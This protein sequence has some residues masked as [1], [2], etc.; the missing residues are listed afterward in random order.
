M[1]GAKLSPPGYIILANFIKKQVVHGPSFR[2]ND[3]WISAR[4]R[5]LQSFSFKVSSF[6]CGACGVLLEFILR[7]ERSGVI[8]PGFP[9]CFNQSSQDFR[10]GFYYPAPPGYEDVQQLIRLSLTAP[11]GSITTYGYDGLNRVND[12]ANSWAGSFGFSYD[13]LSRRTSLTRPNGVNTSYTYDSVSRLLSV[14]HQ[15]GGTTL[16]GASYT[17]DAAGNRTSKTNYL[18]GITDNYAYD[19][20]YQLQQVTEGT[21]TT[22][23]YTYDPVGNRLSSLSVPQYNYNTSNELTSTSLA[24]YSYDHNGNTLTKTDSSGTTQYTWDYENRLTQVTVPQSGGG[25]TLVSFKYDPFGRRIQKSGP[26]GSTNYLYD[27]PNPIEELDSSGNVLA[28][29]TQGGLDEPLSQLRSGVTSYYE[30]DGLGSITSLTDSSGTIAATYNYDSFGTMLSST[31]SIINPFRYTARELDSETGLYYH[32]AR[33][34]DQ[35]TGRFLSEDPLRFRIS[36]NFYPYVGNRPTVHVDPTGRGPTWNFV[37]N[38]W[39]GSPVNLADWGLG[40]AFENAPSVTNAVAFFQYSIMAQGVGLARALCAGKTG[41]QI[42]VFTSDSQTTTDV[43]DVPGLYSVGHSTFFRKA[44][45]TLVADC[46]SHRFTIRSFEHFSIRDWFA[47]PLS[48]GFE[49][50]LSRPYRINYDF[51]R[52]RTIDGTF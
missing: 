42:A 46:C 13:A 37:T 50:P 4:Q 22:E 20:L 3:I 28:R 1:S 25:S 35:G 44:T 30:A 6:R 43:T 48:L 26:D 52:S 17:Y 51:Y 27:S 23:S 15:A 2:D 31:G 10:P 5:K 29:Y 41:K 24:S 8:P 33:Y 36:S 19:A 12:I 32:R 38:Y 21:S 18:N 11:D 39:N 16:D 7:P 9:L 34:F 49:L 14:L 47:D 45:S 40:G